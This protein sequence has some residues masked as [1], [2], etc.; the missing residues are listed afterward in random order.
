MFAS[1]LLQSSIAIIIFAVL[2]GLEIWPSNKEQK[3]RNHMLAFSTA[4]MEHHKNQCYFISAIIVAALVLDRQAWNRF[5]NDEPPPTF[6]VFLSVPLSMNGFLPVTFILA[7]IARYCRLT[8]HI[9]ILSLV[10]IALS[11]G[12]LAGSTYWILKLASAYGPDLLSVNE[13][14]FGFYDDI[15]NAIQIC[16]SESWILTNVLD[17][18]DIKFSLV[19]AIYSYCILWFLWCVAKHVLNQPFMKKHWERILRRTA[20]SASPS[21][22]S[23]IPQ[24]LSSGLGLILLI[25]WAL[26]FTYHF[27]LYSLFTKSKLVS[28]EWS[29]GQIIAVTVWVPWIVEFLYIELG[30]SSPLCCSA[31]FVALTRGGLQRAV[32]KDPNT[33]T[34]PVSK[35]SKPSKENQPTLPMLSCCREHRQIYSRRVAILWFKEQDD[36]LE[37]SLDIL[38]ISLSLS[39]SIINLDC[40]TKF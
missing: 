37:K 8:W 11:T 31:R 34:H 33:N 18:S 2:V 20:G 4:T 27:Y 5:A 19:W 23:K 15:Q 10:S 25:I 16:G 1:L 24:Q 36:D 39:I 28:S 30:K 21:A 6:D 7:C 35:S 22:F 13:A 17:R 32:R 12:T 38:E 29:F 26:C 14:E 40:Q 3:N 9:I